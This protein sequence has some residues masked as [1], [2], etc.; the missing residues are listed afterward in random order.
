M[1]VPLTG[2][3]KAFITSSITKANLETT[4]FKC[5]DYLRNTSTVSPDPCVDMKRAQSL[6]EDSPVP[7]ISGLWDIHDRLKHIG[8]E[9]RE[10]DT[11]MGL[12][13]LCMELKERMGGGRIGSMSGSDGDS[14]RRA[15]GGEGNT[16]ESA[17]AEILKMREEPVT[18]PPTY[19]VIKFS[20]HIHGK[21]LVWLV[22][23]ITGKRLD[24][25][26]E[27][28][29]RKQPQGH[30]EG[31][32]LHVSASSIKFLEVAEELEIKKKDSQGLVREFTVSQL[33]DFLLDGMHVQDLITTADKQY[34]V[35]HELENI[36][37]LEEDIHVPGY[38]TLTLYEGQSI[39]QVCLHWELLD[40]IYPL[41]D[42][43]ALEKLGNKWYWALFEN[44]PFEEIR[45]YFGE[46]VALY[47]T[48]LGFYT[49]ALLVPM[50]LGIL[51]M[52]L[53]SE[54]LAFFCV[55]NVLWVT[56]FL[57]AWKRKC[58]ELAF[59]WGTIGMTG[60]DEPRPNYHGTM[61]IDTITGRYQP[62]FPKWKTYLRMYAVSFPIVFLCMLGAFF[63]MLLSFWTEEYLMARR[64]RGVRMGRL[65]VTLPSIVY[66]ALVYVMNTYYR[67]LA[68]HLTEWG[69]FN[70]Q[71]HRTQSQFDRHRVTKLVLFE[72]V[73]NFMSLFYIAFYIRDM[74]MLRSQLAVMLIILQAIN[75]FQ[76]AMLPLL[77]K[78]YGKRLLRLLEL[79]SF[80]GLLSEDP[81][82]GKGGKEHGYVEG[83]EPGNTTGGGVLPH[84]L[85]LSRD[86]PRIAQATE[87]GEME[88]YEGT[89]DD[90]L[91]MFIQ[92][93]YVFLFS[94][95]FPIAAFWAVFNN[96][97]EVRADAFKLCRV[98]QRPSARRV[99]DTGAWQRA[100]EALG[101]LSIVTNCGL[102]CMSPQLRGL[103]PDLSNVEW[104]LLV[105]CLEHVLL[106]VRHVLHEAI[107][108]VPGW[109]RLAL[110]KIDYQS[111]QALK[112]EGERESRDTTRTCR[113]RQT[114][115][116]AL[117]RGLVISLQPPDTA[118]L[119][120]DEKSALRLA[121]ALKAKTGQLPAGRD[122]R[123][124]QFLLALA[125]SYPELPDT[126]RQ[127]LIHRIN[128]FY[129]V[130]TR[131]WQTAIVAEG[132]DQGP[133][134][135]PPNF[136]PPTSTKV[137]YRSP[138]LSPTGPD[139]SSPHAYIVFT[140][141]ETREERE[142]REAMKEGFGN[143]II[144]C[145]D[146][147]LNPRPS[148]QKSDTLPLYH[149]ATC[150]S[151]VAFDCCAQAL[152]GEEEGGTAK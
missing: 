121:L 53:S 73:N 115:N 83:G 25:G 45:L 141:R 128:I 6:P 60:L 78:Q 23:K 26:A 135:H 72:F 8:G 46:A 91:E 127:V 7:R 114:G 9:F 36:R 132:R 67:R 74:D 151:D 81:T 54:T 144:L 124:A 59:T 10:K 51:Q 75:N 14:F 44:Q 21:A 5:A 148:A 57:E 29:V 95:V 84:I 116:H 104:V 113:E 49:T 110:A 30:G 15:G 32:I 129:I 63:V 118:V 149:P 77:I 82:G 20:R 85:P 106:A 31:L 145:R 4:T 55:F 92:F 52:L 131:C 66:T 86:D 133:A 94:S 96:I 146:R 142:G 105:V 119:Q 61:A 35:R 102:L 99:K 2:P 109:V 22:D 34:I 139:L 100:F 40:S 41:H 123:Q 122:K 152:I 38:P 58:S 111:K 143:Q 19:M 71:N 120:T 62:Q 87:E 108:D 18:F 89:Y 50:V 126:A 88:N 3:W 24:G 150:A 56:L 98:F 68:T 70:F 33:E 39:V 37:A 130:L 65:L 13:I 69:R 140:E 27:L 137:S 147:G 107:P 48:F 134:L 11:W 76:E 16:Q 90:Y 97:L 112:H 125:A 43:E 101:A 80:F 47:F 79:D 17:T 103:A 12:T 117:K 138:L 28:L 136:V 64:E 42:L 93:G 1:L